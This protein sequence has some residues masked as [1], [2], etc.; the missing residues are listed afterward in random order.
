MCKETPL[1]LN[2]MRLKSKAKVEKHF[3]WFYTEYT[4]TETFNCVGDTFKIAPT[5]YADKD[6]VSYWFTGQPNLVE[7]LSGAEASQKISEMEPFVSK[8][9]NDNF[10]QV[11]FDFIVN[12]YDSISNPPVSRERFIELHDS[13]ANYVL[14]HKDILEMEAEEALRSFFHSDAYAIFF[15]EETPCGKELYEEISNHLNIFWFNVQYTLTMPGRVVDAG[16]GEVRDGVVYYPLNGERLIPHDYV[17]TATSHVT[18]LWAYIVTLLIIL[19]AI[20]S[21]FYR[22]KK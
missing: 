21:F 4:F 20:G 8:W 16:T 13:L 11:S 5:N 15:N 12:H 18:N 10:Y 9:L 7:G 17:I 22:R 2:G 6:I 19:L 3:R 1:Q 14:G